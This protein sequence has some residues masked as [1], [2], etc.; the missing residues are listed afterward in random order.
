MEESR[1]FVEAETLLVECHPEE[2]S[3]EGS[4][5]FRL[6]AGSSEKADPSPALRMTSE[7][8]ALRR[9]NQITD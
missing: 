9:S 8:P 1:G 4:V 5:L 2:R 7:K 3:D 6:T